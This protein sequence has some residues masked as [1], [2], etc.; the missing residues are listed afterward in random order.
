MATGPNN[1]ITIENARLIF[2]D[3][4]GER[5]RFNSDRTFGVVLDT[6]FA[7]E[8]ERDGWNVK[9]LPPREDGDEPLCFLPVKVAFNKDPKK[10][11]KIVLINGREKKQMLDEKTVGILDWIQ[12]E[13]ADLIVRPFNYDFNGRTGTKAYLSTLYVTKAVDTLEEKYADIPDEEEMPWGE[14]S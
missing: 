3:F 6:D 10:N 2:R 13:N 12:I 1:R 9:R 8:L 11:P 7:D 14:N 5:N 4:T